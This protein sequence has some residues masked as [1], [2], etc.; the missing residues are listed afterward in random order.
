VFL[1]HPGLRFPE[2]KSLFP[3]GRAVGDRAELQGALRE[4]LAA[5]QRG[6]EARRRALQERYFRL[7]GHAAERAVAAATRWWVERWANQSP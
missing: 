1:D 6:S 4:E 5:P 3:V 7:D 2:E